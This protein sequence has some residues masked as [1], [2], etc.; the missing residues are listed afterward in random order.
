[1]R[2]PSRARVDCQW[3]A[4]PNISTTKPVVADSVTDK[5]ARDVWREVG[6]LHQARIAHRSLHRTNIMIGQDRA[7]FI[8]DFGIGCLLEVANP[9]LDDAC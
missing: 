5:I 9:A 7:V 1:M 6:R 8:L 4:K 2:S 3:N